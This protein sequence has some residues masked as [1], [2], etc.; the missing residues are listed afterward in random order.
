ME[1]IPF[2]PLKI[3]R[4]L[5]DHKWRR[6]L[7]AVFFLPFILWVAMLTAMI[8]RVGGNKGQR[9]SS[10]GRGRVLFANDK[11]NCT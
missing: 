10:K 3:S 6:G 5:V 7:R 9:R 11:E 2:I 8:G 1:K 4:S